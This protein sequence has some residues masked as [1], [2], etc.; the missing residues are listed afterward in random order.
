[1]L[2]ADPV[3]RTAISKSVVLVE[4]IRSI[5]L[6]WRGRN[7][8]AG[9]PPGDGVAYGVVPNQM[10]TDRYQPSACCRMARVKLSVQYVRVG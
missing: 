7:R 8:R 6:R 3:A 10:T 1:M 4:Y 2:R 5:M 9:A